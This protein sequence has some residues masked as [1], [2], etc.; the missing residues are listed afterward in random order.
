MDLSII[1]GLE[2]CVSRFSMRILRRSC[3]YYSWLTLTLVIS[4]KM[5]L[6][7]KLEKCL[8]LMSMLPLTVIT[9]YTTIGQYMESTLIRARSGMIKIGCTLYSHCTNKVPWPCWFPLTDNPCNPNPC[10]NCGTCTDNDDGTFTCTCNE[11][12]MGIYC[13]TCKSPLYFNQS[14]RRLRLGSKSSRTHLSQCVSFRYHTK[15][16]V[17]VF[18]WVIHQIK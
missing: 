2:H 3:R 10:E 7:L 12:W 13:T 9:T 15:L 1:M 18:G 5:S 4:Y 14:G 11:E 8:D 17:V 16:Y 6:R